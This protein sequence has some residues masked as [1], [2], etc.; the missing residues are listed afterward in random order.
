LLETVE[1]GL[2]VSKEEFAAQEPQLRVELINAQYDLQ[3][4]DFSVVLLVVGDD[5]LG[6]NEIIHGMHEWMD[7]RYLETNFFPAPSKEELERPRF[8]RYWRVLPPHGKIG[9]YIG[10]WA[11]NAVADRVRDRIDGDRFARRLAHIHQFEQGLA[12]DGTLVLKYWVHLPRKALKKRL[13]KA[14]KDE[15]ASWQLEEIDWQLYEIYDDTI[16]HI[17]TLL[18]AT[19]TELCP[20]HILDGSNS[21]ARDLYFAKTLLSTIQQHLK[22]GPP[23]VPAPERV[24]TSFPDALSQVDLSQAYTKEGYKKLLNEGQARLAKLTRRARTAG[25]ST[26]LVFEG[27]DAAGK[28]GVIRRIT[29]AMAVRDYRVVPITA[30]TEDERVRHYL[31]RFWR[32]LPPAGQML[33]FDRSWYGRVL[34]ERVEGFAKPDEW[35]RAYDEIRDFETQLTERGIVVQ[36]FWLHIDPDEQLARF[37]AREQTPYK[38]YKITEEDYR[39]RERWDNYVAAVN[40]MVARTSTDAAPWHIIPANDKRYARIQVLDNVCEALK[41]ALKK[42]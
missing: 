21:R 10:A 12:A 13:K 17:E 40:E 20:W 7:G 31:W 19:H 9:V 38:K 15:D 5:R 4:A 11:L 8:W 14:E 34:V 29:R 41:Q 22:S 26:V 33:I 1:T 36:K 30:P 2:K 6:V 42:A 35:Q 28:G 24:T 18:Q 25:Q 23:F 39:N 16:P 27:W 37:K 3:S 32:H